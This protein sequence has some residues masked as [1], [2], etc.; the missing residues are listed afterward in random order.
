MSPPALPLGAFSEESSTTKIYSI[1]HV[2]TWLFRAIVVANRG[3]IREYTPPVPGPRN[4][5]FV[6]LLTIG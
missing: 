6:D 5:A 1:W 2:L 4:S 3:E